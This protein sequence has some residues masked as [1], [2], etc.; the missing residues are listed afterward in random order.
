MGVPDSQQPDTFLQRVAYLISRHQQDQLTAGEA[1]ELRAWRDASPENRFFLEQWNDTR[2][3]GEKLQQYTRSDVNTAWE[4]FRSR[5]FAPATTKRFR[6]TWWQ[7]S[8]AAAIALLAGATWYQ[9][10]IRPAKPLAQHQ[11]Q[12][13]V[14][15]GS[16]KATLTLADGSTITLDSTG[17]Q[18]IAQ[19]AASIHQHNGQL[20]YDIQD[21]VATPALNT[22]TTPRG[23][24]F[25]VTLP[26]GTAVWLNAASSITYPTAFREGNRQVSITGEAYFEVVTNANQP[27]R[28]TVN[29]HTTVDVLGTSFCISAYA[30]ESAISATLV[31]GAVKVNTGNTSR[32]LAPGQQAQIAHGN[33]QVGQADVSAA[34][35]WKN[36][37]FYFHNA[38]I[39]A[40][41]RQ[42]ERWYDVH[43]IYEGNIPVR[44][45]QGEIQR[46]LPLED[47]L[48]GLQSTGIHFHMQGRNI[49]VQP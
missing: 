15:P 35:A 10:S 41:M 48:E 45:F 34:I 28:V 1:E 25:R 39:P 44:T 8:A 20:R 12:A 26:D 30:N 49:I 5:H 17:S 7:W 43:A 27:F 3:L 31:S 46:N 16:S 11:P 40:I 24:Q 13:P 32:V 42:L 4:T 47:V 29:D 18:V 2:L 37:E 23:G 33:I 19:G 36:G 38:D 14:V 9:Q 6:L 22:L 21:P